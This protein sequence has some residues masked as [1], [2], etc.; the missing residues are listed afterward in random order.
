[1]SSPQN[2]GQF[3]RYALAAENE[4]HQQLRFEHRRPHRVQ[5][6]PIAAVARADDE[7]GGDRRFAIGVEPREYVSDI[8]IESKLEVVTR[9]FAWRDRQLTPDQLLE[10]CVEGQDPLRR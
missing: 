4:G 8:E 6:P 2:W 9:L 1:M 5:L 3:W 10:R 7:T